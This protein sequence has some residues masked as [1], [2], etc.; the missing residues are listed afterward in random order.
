MLRVAEHFER[1]DTGRQ[2]RAQR[3][4]LLRARAAVRRSPTGW[5]APRPARSPRTWPSRSSSRACPTAAGRSRSACARVV[6]EANAR[7]M[8]SRPGRRRARRHGHDAH[9][10]LR[11][12]GRRGGRPRRR[13]P[14]LP[15]ARRRAFE[16]LTD[17]HSL[18]EE[19]VRQGKLTPE[20]AEEHPAALDHHARA[21]PRGGRRGR[22]ATRG[23]G[24]DGDV[25]LICSRR[26]DLDDPR[27]AGGRGPG[28]ARRRCASAGRML[29]DAANDAGGRDNITVVLFRLEEVGA[30]ALPRRRRPPSTAMAAPRAEPRRAAAAR[31]RPWHGVQPRPAPPRGTGAPAPAPPARPGRAD[32]RP[33]PAGLRAARRLLRLADRLLRR[34]QQRRLRHAST[35]DC[36]TTCRPA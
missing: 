33:L 5:A 26:A 11:R 30:G 24:R 18:V 20:E 14:R 22:H 8:E 36:P 31:P 29:I 13:Q 35:A 23:A 12:R 2:R 27:G 3:G 1:T 17:D 4:R 34:R 10:R 6:R 32:P 9:R 15:P 25:Y 19:L 16:R 21:R 28:R 7:I